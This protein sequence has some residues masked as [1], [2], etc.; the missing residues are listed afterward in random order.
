MRSQTPRVV[1]RSVITLIVALGLLSSRAESQQARVLSY[2]EPE[3]V[4]MS[5]AVLQG[6]VGLYEEAVERGDLVGAVVLVAR[7][8]RVVL[9][10]AI[11]S[12]D[13]EQGLPMERNTMFR[14]ASNTKPVIATAIAQ[15]VEQD[16]LAYDHL[17]REFIPEWDN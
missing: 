15:L 5:S 13:K 12:K 17:F 16:Q 9:H 6:A 10:Q 7:N 11:G 2:G 14:M 4:G 1:V 3:D 8:G